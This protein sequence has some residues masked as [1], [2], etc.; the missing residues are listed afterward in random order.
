MITNNIE[1]LNHTFGSYQLAEEFYLAI[2]SFFYEMDINGQ[3][4]VDNFVETYIK[5]VD[6]KTNRVSDIIL[7]TGFTKTVIENTL[8]GVK[9]S[10]QFA[11]KSFFGEM[12]DEVKRICSRNEDMT[13]KIKGT[14]NSFTSVFYRLESSTKQLTSHSFLD[15]MIKRGILQKVDENTIR[16]V[17]SFPDKHIN[18]KEKMLKLF[19]NV[20]ERF[21]HTLMTNHKAMNSADENFQQTYRSWHIDPSKH[22]EVRDKLKELVRKHWLEYQA[23]IDGFEVETEFEKNRVEQTGAELGISTFVYNLNLNE[24]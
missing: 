11:T 3:E 16:F 4:F 21:S 9:K 18:T 10:R 15:Y 5:H 23:L 13:M 1:K 20:M 17:R 2:S 12:I 22:D 19:A 6:S 7:N 14:S 8:K 24:E